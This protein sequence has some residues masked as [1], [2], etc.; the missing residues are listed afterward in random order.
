ML[1]TKLSILLILNDYQGSKLG[2]SRKLLQ[3]VPGVLAIGNGGLD[4]EEAR[5]ARSKAGRNL[6]Y[7]RGLADEVSPRDRRSI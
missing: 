4:G 5:R 6:A 1:Y 2:Q 7:R 3:A